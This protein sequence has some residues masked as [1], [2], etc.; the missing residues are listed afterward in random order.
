MG[1]AMNDQPKSPADAEREIFLES[2][3]RESA[4]ERAGFLDRACANNPAI[5]LAVETLLKH[6]KEDEFMQPPGL[7]SAR[8]STLEKPGDRI[9][10]YKLLQQIGEGGCGVVYMAE[11]EEPVR[12][13]VA[14]KVI[15]LGMDTKSVIARFEAERQALALMDHPNI[16]KVQD[17]GATETGRPYFV[18]EL[19]LGTKITEFCDHNNLTTRQRLELFMQVCRA[20]QHA[21]QK[22]II[23]R[24]IKPSNILVALH[25][26]VPVPKVID[27][28]IAKATQGR[29]TDKT[30]FTA[31]QQFIGTPA[32]MSPEQ[33]EMSGLDIDT[34]SDVYSLGVLLYELLTGK[35]PF[36]SN[37][38]L[39]AGLDAMRRTIRE[40]EP[41][42][43]ST[44]LSTMLAGELTTTAS[45]RQT[46][47]PKLL[48]AVRGDLDWIVMK[49]LEKDRARRY[50]TANGLAAD[51]TRHLDN[52]PVVAR[53]PGNL[54]RFQKIVRR[55]KLA[56][57][58]A[59][60]VGAALVLGFGGST[61]M[62]LQER[63][64]LREQARLRLEAQAKEQ[65]A[66]TEAAK[67]R[68][69][70]KFL[71]NMLEGVKPSVA[72]GRD[73]TILREILAN[74]ADRVGQELTN[75]PE[76]QIE[77][78]NVIGSAYQAIDL[79]NH[80]E[81][82]Y[83]EALRIGRKDLGNENLLV[84]QSLYGL[85]TSLDRTG[86]LG[87]APLL[88]EALAVQRKLSGEENED[89]AK[90]LS[91][92]GVKIGTDPKAQAEG[93]AMVREALAIRRKLFGETNLNVA[94]SLDNLGLQLANEH[95]SAEAESAYRQ[96]L[97]IKESI[98][99]P[100][101][102]GLVIDLR[103]IGSLLLEQADE[104]D[105]G[106][107]RD[108]AS[109]KIAQAIQYKREALKMNWQF[110][111]VNDASS[112]ELLN[113]LLMQLRWQGRIAECDQLFED[114]FSFAKEHREP[115]ID[116]VLRVRASIR[117]RDGR[118]TEAADDL[119]KVLEIM[120]SASDRWYPLVALLAYSGDVAGYRA[121]CEKMLAHWATATNA[122]DLERTANA[123]LLLPPEEAQLEAATRVAD[124]A[125]SFGQGDGESDWFRFAQG[126]AE[127][128]Q[129][130]FARVLE[131]AD[132]ALADTNRPMR[133][134]ARVEVTT[135]AAMAH[136]R[137]G[138]AA[139]A[140]EWLVR[141]VEASHTE[142]I[143]PDKIWFTS[144]YSEQWLAPQVLL[145][146]AKELILYTAT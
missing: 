71:E 91:Q 73:T 19:V 6:H 143:P 114:A 138:H 96:S 46:Q 59:A 135:V 63:Q 89:V 9:G 106:N 84:A 108:S 33:A 55:N 15:K 50:E 102:P 69:A 28:F 48:H 85:A 119:A 103:N 30:V 61:R 120:P 45:R 74:A 116:G 23:H 17:A 141:A 43:P 52:E 101:H 107:R 34:R 88:R 2:L 66:R 76:V 72:M 65:S 77:L 126:L 124:R 131:L 112:V 97:A 113:D 70:T 142:L 40:Q 134:S 11:Q 3:K 12:R 90:S 129:G 16:A 86:H 121:L 22:G 57:A 109:A 25:D 26:G 87:E 68:E 10:R 145:R 139:E 146:E 5:R 29:L 115:D 18:M 41:E 37:E 83:R 123:C 82:L 27:F 31:F 99:G 44:K 140:R 144:D 110:H 32:Y 100:V 67:S 95:K 79:D 122:L 81:S 47:P 54:Y 80:A 118:F 132:A 36:D 51:L 35:T 38:L 125:A 104:D 39:Q 130:H 92:L 21:H 105:R 14:L 4:E 98:Y 24:D 1:N 58:C 137:L 49:A 64:A 62:F 128:R 78:L 117:V 127:Y 42:R 56:F 7:E 93:E 75:Q 94:S 53:P 20:I 13:R 136:Q 8:L 133:P 60:I 111:L